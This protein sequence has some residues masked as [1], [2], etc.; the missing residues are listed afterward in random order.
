MVE[1]QLDLKR[2]LVQ[3]STRETLGAFSDRRSS[4]AQGI[5]LIRLAALACDTSLARH[6]LGSDADDLLSAAE[7]EALEPAGAMAAILDRE[8]S[9]GAEGARPSNESVPWPWSRALTVL[10]PMSLPVLALT[11]TAVWLPLCGSTPMTIMCA[12]LRLVLANDRTVGGQTSVAAVATLLSSHAGDPR[13]AA[14]D[15]TFAGQSQG[16]HDSYGSAR[17]SPENQPARSDAITTP[18]DAKADTERQLPPAR[19]RPRRPPHPGE[20]LTAPQPTRR[21][22]SAP[23]GAC[24]YPAKPATKEGEATATPTLKWPSFQPASLA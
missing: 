24:V 23:G 13:A 21:V 4:D 15:T 1:Q 18:K 22:C 2:R 14:G 3:A 17:R 16:R 6:Q 12:S 20:P 5:D 19:Q 10:A 9:P 8:D 7:Q 11:A